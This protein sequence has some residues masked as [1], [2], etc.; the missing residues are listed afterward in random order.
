MGSAQLGIRLTEDDA[1]KLTAFLRA[2]TGRQPAVEN[3]V[4]PPSSDTT[5]RPELK[6]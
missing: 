1:V 6:G 5:P 4:L 2:L 3:P